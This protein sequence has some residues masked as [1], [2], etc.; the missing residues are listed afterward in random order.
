MHVMTRQTGI[1]QKIACFQ[2]SFPHRSRFSL[3]ISIKQSVGQKDYD[4][5]GCRLTNAA[6]GFLCPGNQ[7]HQ[8]LD[9]APATHKTFFLCY[10]MRH[11]SANSQERGKDDHP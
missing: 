7:V 3:T 11:V 2:F 5:F 10:A 8:K 6:T 9:I 4:S 1:R